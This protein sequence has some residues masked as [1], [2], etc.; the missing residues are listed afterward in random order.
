MLITTL[1]ALSFPLLSLAHPLNLSPLRTSLSP[2]SIIIEQDPLPRWSDYN[3]PS[4]YL[5]IHPATIAD[6]QT[7]IRWADEQDLPFIVYGA[8]N[9]WANSSF[10][11]GFYLA[12]DLLSSISFTPDRTEASIQAGALTS[13]VIRAGYA[14]S[15]L[16]L[17][18][19]CDCV[20][21]L[22]ALLGGGVGHLTGEYG[23]LV[24]TLL[25]IDVVLADG[26]LRTVTEETEP[27]L[28]WAL[29]GAGASF[30]VVVGVRVRAYPE[31]GLWAWR[32]SL[33]YSQ[34]QLTPVL[35][36]L[37]E[38]ELS[39]RAA[40]SLLYANRNDTPAIVIDVFYHGSASEA[41]AFFHPLLSLRPISD[42]TSIKAWP[43]WNEP[44]SAA[45][46]K[47][48]R[49]PTW[50]VGLAR[51][52]AAVFARVF[53]VWLELTGQPFARKSSM[54]LNWVSMDKA[55]AVPL[56]D[57]AVPFRDAVAL[58]ATFTVAYEDA[59]FDDEALRYGRLVRGLWRGA[60]GLERPLTW[61]LC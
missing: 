15:S 56:G 7:T 44:S 22:G 12:L 33:V 58:F 46:T 40:V 60:D 23:L 10:T 61:V 28:W 50:G 36:V 1:L 11:H 32:G 14:A 57:S 54:L 16:I 13:D 27:E 39:P 6:V 38:L 47:G 34:G 30:G 2:S 18:A 53:Q 17:T 51:F 29:R 41:T 52:N 21:F 8:G 45:C 3:A 37:N 49:K 24:D 55:R 35:D 31:A 19:T 20:S 26:S 59:G 9:D 5:T 25:S 43:E 42:T 4:P 48:G